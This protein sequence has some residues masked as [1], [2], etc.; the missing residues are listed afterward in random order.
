MF[1]SVGLPLDAFGT[2]IL[3]RKRGLYGTMKVSASFRVSPRK[4]RTPLS[5]P[6]GR[7]MGHRVHWETCTTRDVTALCFG[8]IMKC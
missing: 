7:M 3:W 6:V 5:L 2:P 4:A 8:L 1:L